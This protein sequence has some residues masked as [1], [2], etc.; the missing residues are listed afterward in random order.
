VLDLG[1]V[2]QRP[3]TALTNRKGT[4]AGAAFLSSPESARVVSIDAVIEAASWKRSA[5]FENTLASGDHLGLL[6][7]HIHSEPIGGE[8]SRDLSVG[9]SDQ[10][11]MMLSKTPEDVV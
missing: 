5:P 7:E 6:S 11:A 2:W 4:P 8:L 3:G 9:W 1:I 10:L